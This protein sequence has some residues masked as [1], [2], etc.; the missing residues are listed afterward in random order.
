[1][2]KE[3]RKVGPGFWGGQGVS[4]SLELKHEIQKMNELENIIKSGLNNDSAKHLP[5]V[6]E[7]TL[8]A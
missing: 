5:K 8:S 2:E 7:E 1:M 6:K 3:T 4:D